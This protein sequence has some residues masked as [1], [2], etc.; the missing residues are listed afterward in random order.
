M[1]IELVGDDFDAG[2]GTQASLAIKGPVVPGLR[3][4]GIISL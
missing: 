4:G 1:A 2:K 3:G